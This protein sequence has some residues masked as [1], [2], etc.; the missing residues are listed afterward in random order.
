MLFDFSDEQYNVKIGSLKMTNIYSLICVTI[1]HVMIDIIY[2]LLLLIL[3]TL[4]LNG[5]SYWANKYVNF[6]GSA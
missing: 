3:I 2:P 1:Y 4:T 5:I 6:I